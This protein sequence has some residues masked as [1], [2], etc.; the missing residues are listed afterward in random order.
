LRNCLRNLA[1][2]TGA[3]LDQ[4]ASFSP[5]IADFRLAMEVAV[6]Q[7]LARRLTAIL[8]VRDPLSEKVHLKGPAVALIG[9]AGVV[10][11][12]FGR[13]GRALAPLAGSYRA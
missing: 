2:R 1:L 12:A 5:R 3:L 4:S 13:M 10:T 6:I 11:G 9:I 7:A 8:L